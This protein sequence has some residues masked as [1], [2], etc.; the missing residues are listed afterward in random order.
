TSRRPIAS[1]SPPPLPTKRR[2]RPRGASRGRSRRPGRYSSERRS[3]SDASTVAWLSTK[4][5][6]MRRL[7]ITTVGLMVLS[8]GSHNAA[9]S[10]D[11]GSIC[12]R[13]GGPP[14]SEARLL[15]IERENGCLDDGAQAPQDSWP[16]GWK[17]ATI[18]A[19]DI[20]PA[21]VISDPYPT[22]HSVVVDS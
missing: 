7:I 2:C 20:Q 22:L 4:G 5:S 12:P 19:G 10:G 18:A 1:S 13:P 21:R 16:P 17:Q 14:L 15:A 9:D 11:P 8:L 3:C 6:G